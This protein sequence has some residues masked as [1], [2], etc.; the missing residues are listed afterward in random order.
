MLID[1]G[2]HSRFTEAQEDLSCRAVARLQACGVAKQLQGPH[3]WTE[4]LVSSLHPDG[5]SNLQATFGDAWPLLRAHSVD[6]WRVHYG[7]QHLR[8]TPRI[9]AYVRAN[10]DSQL[11]TAE[12]AASNVDVGALFAVHADDRRRGAQVPTP[13]MPTSRVNF[14]PLHDELAARLAG[15]WWVKNGAEPDYSYRYWCDLHVSFSLRRPSNEQDAKAGYWRLLASHPIESWQSR[16]TLVAQRL[17][18][19]VREFRDGDID[20]TLRTKT[21]RSAGVTPEAQRLRFERA[22]VGHEPAKPKAVRISV[23]SLV[24][25]L[26]ARS[27]QHALGG[28]S[29]IIS[30]P[31]RTKRRRGKQNRSCIPDLHS[32]TRRVRRRKAE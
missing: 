1:S 27:P 26:T 11:R 3:L 7:R 13:A 30:R 20:G 17:R 6:Q 9:E 10:I 8:L 31:T 2:Y 18:P 23:A 19:L 32:R 15:R 5:S 25:P 22:G 4:V 24:S 29:R 16:F 21:E 12:E 28:R 14:T